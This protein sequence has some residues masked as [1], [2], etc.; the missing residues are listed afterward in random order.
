MENKTKKTKKGQV[1]ITFEGVARWLMVGGIIL[2]LGVVIITQ[3]GA[4]LS[5]NGLTTVATNATINN[6]TTAFTTAASL[7]SLAALLAVLAFI[8]F[9]VYAAIG[10]ASGGQQGM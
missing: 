6:V 5:S 2:I 4:N 9:L 10:G 7:M 1:S 8:L 3:L